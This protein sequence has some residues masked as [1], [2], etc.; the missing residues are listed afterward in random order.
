MTTRTPFTATAST[1]YQKTDHDKMPKGWV[2]HGSRV[3]TQANIGTSETDIADATETF[4]CVAGRRY[5][6]L[7]KG[8]VNPDNDPMEIIMRLYADGSQI[9]SHSWRTVVVSEDHNFT[10]WG[11]FDCS[12]SG[13]KIF[14]MTGQANT[15]STTFDLNASAITPAQLLVMDIGPTP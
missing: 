4:S 11:V 5:L 12:V 2:A 1:K 10:M 15:G 13:A 7:A 14:K 3:S 9:D 6:V 8:R